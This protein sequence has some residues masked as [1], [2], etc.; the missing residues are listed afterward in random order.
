MKG[1]KTMKRIT[2][3]FLA[4]VLC[5]SLT[6]CGE[7]NKAEKSVNDIFNA[8]KTAN[9][10]KLAD[11]ADIESYDTDDIKQ[12]EPIFKAIAEN[13]DYKIISSEQ[14][15][16]NSVKVKTEITVSDLSS[17]FKDY[18]SKSMQYAMSNFSAVL[19]G[20]ISQEE[21]ER[22][23]QEIMTECLKNAD[24]SKLVTQEIDI[25]VVKNDDNKWK[26]QIDTEV[27]LAIYK[28]LFSEM[29]ED[30]GG[31]MQSEYMIA[32]PDMQNAMDEA[33]KA[34]TPADFGGYVQGDGLNP[35]DTAAADAQRQ[36]NEMQ[37]QM[38]NMSMMN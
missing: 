38:N 4:A 31:M 8:I 15:E 25:R 3:I 18:I 27:A 37:Q 10:D 17:F 14:Q 1:Y 11:Y 6:A 26:A 24:L 32:Q 21:Q 35:S 2:A 7:I 20:Q 12:A 28:G 34:V 19:S 9:I 13:F 36:M 30:L 22:Q 33:M 23:M 5:M 29:Y 16:D